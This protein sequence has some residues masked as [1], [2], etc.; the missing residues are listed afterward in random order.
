MNVIGSISDSSERYASGH[1][2]TLENAIAA[3]KEIT[4]WSVME[5][6]AEGITPDELGSRYRMFGEDPFIVSAVSDESPHTVPFSAWRYV[7][8][9]LCQKIIRT[10]EEDRAGKRVAGE[11]ESPEQIV[12]RLLDRTIK[13]QSA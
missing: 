10:V 6:C 12:Q 2:A 7:S 9:E 13:P 4:I 1:Y 3:C 5:Q 8:K 11:A